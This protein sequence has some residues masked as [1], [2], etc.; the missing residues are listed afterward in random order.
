MSSTADSVPR[1]PGGVAAWV[2][3]ARP[4][5]LPAA[6]APVLLGTAFAAADDGAHA[7]AAMACLMGGLF[8]QI[9]TNFCND[10]Y[11]FRKGA[12]TPTRRGPTRAVQAG[13]ISPRAMLRGAGV[14][15][16]GAALVCAYLVTRGGLP[17][18]AVGVLSIAFAVLYTA[19]PAP[20]AYV[21]LGDVFVLVFFG[22]I[23]TCTT[24]Y[25]QVGGLSGSVVAAS[26][27]PGLFSTALL[28]V[29]NLRDVDGD[30]TANK[31][32]LA[33]RFGRTFARVEY[34]VC[35]VGGALVPIGIWAVTGRGAWSCLSAAVLLLAVPTLRRLW[36]GSPE[37]LPA[38]LP[39]TA[40]LL[41]LHT[42]VFAVGWVL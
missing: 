38:A 34:T 7:L 31:R 33:V 36:A 13:L 22:L 35:V 17:V 26:F 42:V 15:L 32:T 1:R 39:E 30:R 18:L 3:A 24:Y 41:V 21:G 28:T 9:G 4:K 2:L 37:Q 12:D 10:Y 20:L 8:V 27:A 19:G 16:A 11:D 6:I 25:V 5:T 14:V 29:N 23:A 40:R